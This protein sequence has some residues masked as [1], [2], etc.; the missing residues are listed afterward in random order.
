MHCTYALFYI[1][2]HQ[3]TPSIVQSQATF[4]AATLKVSSSATQNFYVPLCVHVYVL[5][6]DLYVCQIYIA[7][8][9]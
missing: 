2:T 9:P 5:S 7:M 1:V 3:V 6:V 4:V 8:L